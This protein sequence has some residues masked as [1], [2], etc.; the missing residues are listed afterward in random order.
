MVEMNRGAKAFSGPDRV[1]STRSKDNVAAVPLRIGPAAG[2]VLETNIAAGDQVF[3]DF[4]ISERKPQP[5]IPK[6][7]A[8]RLP[9]SLA[10]PTRKCAACC[11]DPAKKCSTATLNTP[12]PLKCCEG[13]SG[14][15]L[16]T[17]KARRATVCGV[18][19]LGALATAGDAEAALARLPQQ[20]RA[21]RAGRYSWAL[22]AGANGQTRANAV[23]NPAESALAYVR[24]L[25]C[26]PA[27]LGPGTSPLPQ[28]PHSAIMCQHPLGCH[29]PVYTAPVQPAFVCRGEIIGRDRGGCRATG[30]QRKHPPPRCRR[31]IA[32]RRCGSLRRGA[33]LKARAAKGAMQVWL[34]ERFARRVLGGQ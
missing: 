25:L 24:M 1:P 31:K 28:G 16:T 10:G 17:A 13:P 18:D 2:L 27:R 33:M 22:M 26:G 19:V 14:L 30:V 29:E 7:F 8:R 6:I 34:E 3:L 15:A 11:T 21:I 12:D 9:R 32:A 4:E 20:R 5:S 23:L